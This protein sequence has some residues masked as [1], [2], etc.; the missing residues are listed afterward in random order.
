M[1]SR[2]PYIS[3]N[4]HDYSYYTVTYPHHSLTPGVLETLLP[5]ILPGP[6]TGPGGGHIHIPHVLHS[7]EHHHC[8]SP[9]PQVI[10]Q[11]SCPEHNY[12]VRPGDSHAGL[13]CALVQ[14]LA[15][16]RVRLL[17]GHSVLGR[18]EGIGDDGVQESG[19]HGSTHDV[20]V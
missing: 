14:Q 10:R 8:M 18:L 16:L 9:T 20:G 13:Q 3:G 11:E 2:L 12:P 6:G 1:G 7:H 17:E 4:N 5:G 15:G 19:G